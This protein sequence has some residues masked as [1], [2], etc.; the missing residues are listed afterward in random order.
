[1]KPLD[2]NQA[3][4]LMAPRLAMLIGSRAPE[5]EPDL[6]P[7]TNV[8]SISNEPEQVAI[9]IYKEWTTYENLMA[10]D[11]FTISIPT[12]DQIDAV[13]RLGARYS[14]FKV[15]SN[16]EKLEKCGINISDDFS[17]YGPVGEGSYGWLEARIVAKE[18][19]GGDHGVFIGEVSKAARNPELV[20]EDGKPTKG[21]SAVFQ[22]AGNLLATNGELI[23]M[24]YLS[25]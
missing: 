3:H 2:K 23:E 7:A 5:G 1:M 12:L 14:G 20:A 10:A 13:W 22:V 4:R 17:P 25:D 15:S 11:G 18:T 19:F 8:T 16:A 6:M 9:A 21:L 24:E